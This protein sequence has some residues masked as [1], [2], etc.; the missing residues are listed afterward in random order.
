MHAASR[1]AQARIVDGYRQ[2]LRDAAMYPAIHYGL[3]RA[4]IADVHDQAHRGALARA[5]RQAR[6][7]HARAITMREGETRAGSRP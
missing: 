7:R 3:A 5:A 2:A 4:R 1:L 6:R